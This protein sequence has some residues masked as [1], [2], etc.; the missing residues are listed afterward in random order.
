MFT[1]VGSTIFPAADVKYLPLSKLAWYCHENQEISA[2]WSDK[3]LQIQ[4]RM[5]DRVVR[6]N[7]VIIAAFG[8]AA[9]VSIVIAGY[10]YQP[11][12]GLFV[13]WLVWVTSSGGEHGLRSRR[14][15][16]SYCAVLSTDTSR[17]SQRDGKYKC[18]FW[19][20]RLRGLHMVQ[21]A[22]SPAIRTKRCFVL[23]V[24]ISA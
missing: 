19:G 24:M 10:L 3:I 22:Y 20:T 21:R 9:N 13:R 11:S 7:Q 15:H 2:R 18:F 16:D 5:P 14:T 12:S 1:G 23:S 17:F 4:Q 8:L 6:N